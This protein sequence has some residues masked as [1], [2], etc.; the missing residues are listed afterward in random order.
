MAI[1]QVQYIFNGTTYNLTKNTS[2]GAYEATV[3]APTKS[4]YTQEG[5]YYKGTVTAEDMA[6]NKD[7]VTEANEAGL[8]I[9][10]KEKTAPVIS[11]SAPTAGQLLANNKPTFAFT[12]TDADSGVNPDT[13]TLQID[14]QTAVAA[15][16]MTNS[17]V[18]NGYQFTYVPASALSDGAHTVK[19]NAKD[20]DGNAAL[21]ATRTFTVDTVPPTLSVTAPAAGLVTN[22]KNLTVRGTTNDVTSSPCTVTVKLN[23]V[24]AGSVTVASDGSFSKDLTL[25]E[26]TNTITVVATDGVGKATTVTRTVNLDTSPPVIKGVT[27]TPN[28]VDAGATFVIS[29][30]VED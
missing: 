2:T 6:G 8:K 27:L 9:V 29:V 3:T 19:I 13:V 5:H 16:A 20:F 11:V 10:V 14:S 7:T 12:V 24:S 4:S 28:P 22:N 17:A 21:Q 23:A 18:A 15:S 26:G 1:K 30:V 25:T